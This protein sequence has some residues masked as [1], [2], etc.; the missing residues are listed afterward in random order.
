MNLDLSDKQLLSDQ[1]AVFAFIELQTTTGHVSSK[2]QAL[3]FIYWHVDWNGI[4][5][6][7]TK[8]IRTFLTSLTS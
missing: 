5:E 2:L 3:T 4:Y 8:G 1:C 6:G 7:I